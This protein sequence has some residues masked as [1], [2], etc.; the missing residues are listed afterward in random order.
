MKVPGVVYDSPN[1]YTAAQQRQLRLIPPALAFTFRT[2]YRLN[3]VDVRGATLFDETLSRHGRAL[4]ALW[5]ETTGMLLCHHRNRNFHSTASFSF[6]GELA[7]RTVSCFGAECVRGSSSRGGSI[8]LDQL[9]RALENGVAAAGLT[10]DGPRGPRRIAKPGLAILAARTQTWIVPNAAAA[11]RNMRLK[12]WDRFLIPKPFGRI[13][14]AFGE[15]IPPPP[16]SSPEAVEATRLVIQN[17]LNTLQREL[18]ESV[19]DVQDVAQ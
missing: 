12:S 15:P 13:V 5:H 8:A 3:R 16:D 10:M 4:I 18:E 1:T 9:E 19:R 7:A 11:T 14:I 17:S 6:D 2:L